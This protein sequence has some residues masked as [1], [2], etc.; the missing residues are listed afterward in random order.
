MTS[1]A[2]RAERG[3]HRADVVERSGRKIGAQ[4]QTV[5]ASRRVR[6][7]IPTSGD[8]VAISSGVG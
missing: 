6:S 4:H 2:Q 3:L 7:S 5:T 1:A 8:S